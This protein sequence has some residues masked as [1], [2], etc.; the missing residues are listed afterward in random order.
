MTSIPCIEE[1]TEPDEAPR[2]AVG[3]WYCLMC[4]RDQYHCCPLHGPNA[5][6]SRRKSGPGCNHCGEELL[7]PQSIRSGHC[8]R[9][10][11]LEYRWGSGW[12]A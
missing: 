10:Q 2:I 1:T 7:A 4:P 12:A 5:T 6:I 11:P 3:N 8:Q 9:C